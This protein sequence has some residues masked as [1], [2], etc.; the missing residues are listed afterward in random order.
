MS[1]GIPESVARQLVVRG[2]FADVLARLGMAELQADI[3]GR[4]A[5]R[6]GLDLEPG[7]GDE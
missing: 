4:I 1:R 3:V 6:L 7:D 2:F 5:A